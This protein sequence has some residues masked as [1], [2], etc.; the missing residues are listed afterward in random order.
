[1]ERPENKQESIKKKIEQALNQKDGFS[2]KQ[3]Y[4]KSLEELVEE[5]K[6]YQIELEFQNEELRRVQQ[7]LEVSRNDYR[8]MFMSAPV[9]YIIIDDNHKIL[10]YNDIFIELFKP[11]II[12]NIPYDLRK[13]ISPDYQ[14]L[15]HHFSQ[16]LLMEGKNDLRELKMISSHG[17]PRYMNVRG[18]VQHARSGKKKQYRISLTDI[19]ELVNTERELI[20]SQKRLDSVLQSQKE[21]ICR[22]RKDTSLTYVNSAYLREFNKQY[23]ELTGMKWI[24]WVNEKDQNDILQNLNKL[25]ENKGGVFEHTHEVE[26][27]D[28]RKIWYQWVNYAIFDKGKF[29]EFQSV[30]NNVQDKIERERLEKEVEIAHN[31]LKFKQNFLASMSHEMRTPLT[32]IV[33]ITE[34]LKS[35]NLNKKQHDYIYTLAQSSDNLKSVIDQVLDYSNLESGKVQLK[36]QDYSIRKLVAASNEFHKTICLKPIAF[37]ISIDDQLED[38][39]HFDHRRIFQVIKNLI[40]NAVKFTPKGSV[41]LKVKKN[42]ELENGRIQVKIIITDTGIGI[43][44]EKQEMLFSPFSQVQHIDT[45]RYRGIGL[46]LSFCKEI[47]ELHQ[48]DIGLTSKPGKGTTVWFTFAAQKAAD[49]DDNNEPAQ[50]YSS[51]TVNNLH[52]LLVEDK[53]V[54]QKVVSLMLK[55]MGHRVIVASNGKEALDVFPQYYFDMILMDI[56]MPVMDGITATQQ[57]KEQYADLPPIVGLSANAFEGDRKKYM[58]LGLD[59]YLTKPVRKEDFQRI[60]E[61]VLQPKI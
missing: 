23:D 9:S 31:T 45:D 7:E 43:Q 8:E 44:Q 55:D 4:T 36:L 54:T 18:N 46:G 53:S 1:M 35:T 20:R 47:V 17:R 29:V 60:I 3:S 11:D 61:K 39:L 5:L 6:V 34:L 14:D 16:K 56:Q 37:N 50:G 33:G 48:G 58:K 32:A 21:M 28:G 41:E 52:I 10:H 25:I 38:M 57:L 19:T 2:E 15:Y 40:L 24:D 26:H 42:K 49:Y 22:F 27:A 59:E 30:G 13:L 12:P 51:G